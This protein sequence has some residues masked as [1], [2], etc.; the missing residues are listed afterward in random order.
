MAKASTVEAPAAEYS[1][2][3]EPT[4]Y[5]DGECPIDGIQPSPF[6]PRKRFDEGG[7]QELA[8]SIKAH[9]LME[10]IVVRQIPGVEAWG[11]VPWM[12]IVAG[13]RRWRACKIAGLEKVS[14]RVARSLDDEAAL[15]LAIIENVQRQDLDPLEEA[16]GYR[17]LAKLGMKQ[18]Q[19]AESVKRS[20]PAIA[21]AMRLLDLPE[22]VQAKIT[23]GGLSASHGVAL[24]SYKVNRHVQEGLAELAVK[25]GYAS[26]R[27]EHFFA[28]ISYVPEELRQ[29]VY[30][31]GYSTDFDW[32][33]ECRGA[34][35]HEAFRAGHYDHEGFCLL[36]N[37]Y[38]KKQ[39]AAKQAKVQALDTKLQEA[40]AASGV[41]LIKAR[42][43]GYDGTD[44]HTI[45]P[46]T[47]LPV[48]CQTGCAK[49]VQ[50]LDS[51]GSVVEIC[52]DAKCW[53]RLEMAATKVKNKA[54]RNRAKQLLVDLEKRIDGLQVFGAREMAVL[55][56]L[57]LS[58]YECQGKALEQVLERLG[59]LELRA[60]ISN[61]P[62]DAA[63]KPFSWNRYDVLAECSQVELARVILEVAIRLESKNLSENPQGASTPIADWYL[64][65]AAPTVP[66]PPVPTA[67]PVAQMGKGCGL[68]A[69]YAIR[70]AGGTA[71]YCEY[72][73]ANGVLLLSDAGDPKPLGPEQTGK[74]KCIHT[75]AANPEGVDL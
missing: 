36:P 45:Y 50:A 3:N 55:T 32:R 4:A 57:A 71:F 34:C 21:N 1:A 42:D 9:G 19:I 52:S 69:R 5:T 61:A 10:P 2:R 60:A 24:A 46:S 22:S 75:Y 40:R 63:G 28:S 29:Y 25:E 58:S 59:L 26:K 54:G 11:S 48:G 16:E 51:A 14:V 53:K 68:S 30:C 44:Y 73:M 66:E 33:Q 62:Y 15:K 23:A 65:A 31:F 13:E 20:Q 43:L 49:R 72:H 12:E 70:H 6:N 47:T 27:L 38:E 17:Q 7:L 8:D 56:T 74:V 18:A 39:K 35:P 64:A 37:C 67:E 41:T